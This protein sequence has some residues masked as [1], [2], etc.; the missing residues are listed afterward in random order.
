MSIHNSARSGGIIGIYFRFSLT[1]DKKITLNYPNSA[2]M[3]F[4]AKGLKMEFETAMVNKPSVFKPLKFYFFLLQMLK[5]QFFI[6]KW[7]N[8]Y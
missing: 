6:Q 5:F 4:Y 7:S 8:A 3:G 2:A 1:R